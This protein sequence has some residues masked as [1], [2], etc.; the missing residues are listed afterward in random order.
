MLG[1]LAE[2]GYDY[3]NP[4]TGG[5]LRLQQSGANT[6]LQVDANGA[7]GGGNWTTLA[8]LQN[9]TA[10]NIDLSANLIPP[11][12]N[13]SVY[14]EG[15][16]GNDTISDTAGPGDLRAGLGN[17]TLLGLGGNDLLDGASGGADTSGTPLAVAISRIFAAISSAPLATT[18]G[19]RLRASS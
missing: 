7:T 11:L 5:W 10:A 6:L 8:T 15:T 19:A 12:G 14:I 4:F 2:L 3:G 18:T 9:V 13:D 1:R 16:A 17:D